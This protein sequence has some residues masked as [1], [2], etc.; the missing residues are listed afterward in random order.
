MSNGSYQ[1]F[2]LKP[3]MGSMRSE[4]IAGLQQSNK[5]ISPKYF[6]NESGSELFEEIT[7]L[8]EYYLT[9]TE[10][11]LFEAHSAAIAEHLEQ[12]GCLVEYGSG[13][14]LKIRKLLETVQPEAY[15]PV[16]ISGDHLQSNARALQA[17]YPWLSLYPVCT[18][19]TAAFALPAPVRGLSKTGF[20]PGSSIGNFEPAAAVQLLTNI[21]ATLGSGSHLLLGV[22]RK[23]DAAQLEAAYDDAA[24][25]TAAFNLNMLT[26][27]NT[28]LG[29]DFDISKFRHRA[30]Y[31]Q[32]LGCVQM[33]LTSTCA[34]QVAIG[35]VVIEF[36]QDEAIHTENSFKYL[37]EE[38]AELAGR[39]GFEQAAFWTDE[40]DWYSVFLLRVPG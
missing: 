4:V 12:G 38:F 3:A 32:D 5:Q 16:D 35:D 29:A 20:F 40:Q 36:A 18:D 37:P 7:R 30:S 13:S 23:K 17:D 27:L 14:S 39:A 9:R 33:F 19:F 26:H 22:D 24:G 25:V 28:T 1:F 31:N 15:V 10:I 6:Y 2:D 11:A 8:P 34:Q 21:C